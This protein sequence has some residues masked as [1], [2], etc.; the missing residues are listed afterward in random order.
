MMFIGSVIIASF[1]A[2]GTLSAI[3]AA[4]P[5]QDDSAAIGYLIGTSVSLILTWCIQEYVDL[6]VEHKSFCCDIL[7]FCT[8]KVRPWH[9][10]LA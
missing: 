7:K 2:A 9:I 6:I 3:A 4:I 5:S 10:M 8:A 1:G